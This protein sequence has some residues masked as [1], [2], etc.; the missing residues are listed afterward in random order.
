MAHS[1]SPEPPAFDYSLP[2]GSYPT[3]L[4]DYNG[5]AT[6]GEEVWIAFTGTLEDDPG[7]DSVIWAVLP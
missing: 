7:S 2:L 1:T 4:T 5:V 6:Y 3:R